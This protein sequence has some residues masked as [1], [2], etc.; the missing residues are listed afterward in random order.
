MIS[1]MDEGN[2]NAICIY[3]QKKKGELKYADRGYAAV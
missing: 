1:R 2:H 3:D